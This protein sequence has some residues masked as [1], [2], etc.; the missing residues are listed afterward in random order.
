MVV[1]RRLVS[2]LVRLLCAIMLNVTDLDRLSQRLEVELHDPK[3]KD[4]AKLGYA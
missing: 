2:L 1:H 3:D 4:Q